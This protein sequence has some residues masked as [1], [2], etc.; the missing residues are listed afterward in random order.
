MH[1]ASFWLNLAVWIVGAVAIL[2]ALLLLVGRRYGDRLQKMAVASGQ[3]RLFKR[4]KKQYPLLAARLEGFSVGEGSQEALQAAMRK[5]NPT[6]GMKFQA[7]LNRLRENFV[8]R[9][10]EVEP[11]ARMDGTA[12]AKA[13]GQA[14]DKLLKLP[15]PQRQALEKDLL[16][17]WD[18]LRAKAPRAMGQFEAVFK[19]PAS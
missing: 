9:H 19:K 13:Q 14:I 3:K 8:G 2:F 10:P 18:Q 15:E 11:L 6:E 1:N 16:W 5:L 12:D 17:A 4:L 7:E